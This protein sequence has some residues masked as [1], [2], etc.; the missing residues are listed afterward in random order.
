[1][2]E[3][4]I[5]GARDTAAQLPERSGPPRIET[6]EFLHYDLA[7][8]SQDV[9]RGLRH[10]HERF[11]PIAAIEDGGQRVVFLFCPELNQE[12]LADTD[13]FHARFFAI[14]GPRNSAQ[15]RLTCGLLAMNGEQHRRNRRIV[16]EPFGLRAISNYGATISRLT[17][18]MLAGW[19]VGEVRDIA[20]DMRQYML[21]VTSTLLFGLEEPELAFRLGDM[22]AQWVSL[23]DEVGVGALV[24][25][26]RFSSLYEELLQF[27]DQ[28]E[29]EILAMIRR[30]RSSGQTG[31]DVLSILIHSHDEQGGLTDEEL[32]GQ[33]SVLFAAAHMTTAHSLTWT[34]FLLAQHPSAMRRLWEEI[35]HDDSGPHSPG[36]SGGGEQPAN[37]RPQTDGSLP[38]GDDLTFLDCVI[39]ESM[40]LLPA[41]AYSQRINIEPVQLGPYRLPRG[42]GIVFTPI[43][44]H[45][46]P[47]LYPQPDRFLPDRWLTVR[48]SP[49]AYHPFGAGPRLCIGGPLAT[50]I[51]RIALR[52]ILKRVRLRILPGAKIGAHVEA[53]MLF[54]THGMPMQIA[55]PDLNFASSPISGNIHELV[56][57][58]EAPA[59]P[60]DLMAEPPD[61]KGESAAPRRPR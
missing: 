23:N 55:A 18:E 32:V 30:R 26:D 39:K 58:Y 60:A 48:P 20:E 42:T 47:D 45:R 49:Y 35:L 25:N 54:P 41:S 13:R 38:K 1:V 14:R 52:M 6:G 16:K 15:R 11:G 43:I 50:A 5:Q 12:V 4:A 9:L 51:Q 22:I 61:D 46:L 40:R 24:P 37:P 2:P 27:A 19:R 33:T 44:T 7:E 8:L 21:R 56:D 17:E 28:L 10:L 31:R 34:L 3:V 59:F 36:S 53:T 57:L 29:A